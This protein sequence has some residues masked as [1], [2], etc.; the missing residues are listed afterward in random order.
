MAREI[1]ISI[2]DEEVFER[3][4]ARKRELD[5]SWEEVLYRG[6]R[7]GGPPWSETQSGESAGAAGPGPFVAGGGGPGPGG[8]GPGGFDAPPGFRRG[9]GTSDRGSSKDPWDT[10][11]ESIEE[12]VQ[13]RVYDALRS[14]VGA[15]GIDVPPEA[16]LE[17][18][19]ETLQSAEDATL[20]FPFLDDDPA[21]RVPLRVNLRTSPGGLDVEVV[22]V[23]EGKG[24]DDQNDFDGATRA[25][26]TEALAKGETAL[27][28]L[29]DGAER[30]RVVPVLSWG[31]RA[32]GNPRVTDVEIQE[33]VFDGE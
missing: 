24:V 8:P 2:D 25:R 31:R 14:S 3:M 15:M 32:D 13:E 23:R 10:L 29:A 33:V 28:T 4:K 20:R 26:I 18:E 5:L 17:E 11:A 7:I 22:T 9:T 6:L 1:R 30:Y 27:L 21:S 12:Q 19:V 16:G